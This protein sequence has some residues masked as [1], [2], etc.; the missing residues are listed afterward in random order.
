MK[1]QWPWEAGLDNAFHRKAGEIT[2]VIIKNELEKE[3]V[4]KKYQY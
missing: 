2:C 1:S 4:E 3:K